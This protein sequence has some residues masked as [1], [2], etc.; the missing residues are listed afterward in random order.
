VWIRPT[1]SLDFAFFS[2]T[3]PATN[4]RRSLISTSSRAEQHPTGTDHGVS[5]H[6][7][8]QVRNRLL[9]MSNCFSSHWFIVCCSLSVGFQNIKYNIKGYIHESSPKQDSF[10]VCVCERARS[11]DSVYTRGVKSKYSMFI[12][13]SVCLSVAHSLISLVY[14]SE[15]GKR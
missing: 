9:E 5:I 8:N 10:D 3:E 15:C 12:R 14:P 11:Y 2:S 6:T 4:W 1:T 13:L 7:S